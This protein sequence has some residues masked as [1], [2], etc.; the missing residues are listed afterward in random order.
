[1]NRTIRLMTGAA[2]L[3]AASQAHAQSQTRDWYIL[4]LARGQ[5]VPAVV[6]FPMAPSPDSYRYVA[7]HTGWVETADVTRADDGNVVLVITAV[8]EPNSR[9][10][11][12]KFLWYPSPQLC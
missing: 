8:R 7:E 1:M 5:C 4:D 2:L 3:F 6:D 10:I 9:R 11:S 12:A